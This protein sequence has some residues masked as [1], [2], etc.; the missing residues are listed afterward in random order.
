MTNKKQDNK[1]CA[2]GCMMT[3][4]L[5]KFFGFWIN[6][7]KGFMGWFYKNICCCDNSQ[8][9]TKDSKPSHFADEMKKMKEEVAAEI[10]VAKKAVKK[11]VS[12]VSAKTSTTKA[13]AAKPSAKKAVTKSAPVKKQPQAKKWRLKKQPL[14]K[15]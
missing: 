6:Q 11:A 8:C 4:Y 9:K 2:S 14:Q 3:S 13:K 1:S 5:S 12:K 10:S 15:K 7:I